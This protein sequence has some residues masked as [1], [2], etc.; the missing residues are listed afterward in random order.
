MLRLFVLLLVL[1]NG[2]Y[3]AWSQGL[4]GGLGLAPVQQSEPQR[5]AQQIRPDALHLLTPQEPG[6]PQAPPRITSAKTTECLQAGLFDEVQGVLLRRTL[7]ASLPANSW[8]LDAVETPAR[9]IVYMGKF[10]STDELASKRAQLASLNLK[11]EPLV[12]PALAPGLSLGGFGTQAAANEALAALIQRGVRTA[13][14]LQERAEARGLLLRLPSVD[15]ALRARLDGL[16]PVLAGNPW[17]P[18][19]EP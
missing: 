18:C 8:V 19:A 14:V 12:N 7:V 16:T 1:L 11:F 5:L 9:W 3:F 6:L 17:T 13:R 2:L 10:A 15:E 4:L